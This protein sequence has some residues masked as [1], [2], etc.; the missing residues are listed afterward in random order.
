MRIYGI[1][2]IKV[3]K[4]F[5]ILRVD[6]CK[7]DSKSK[8]DLF[9]TTNFFENLSTY[10]ES[11]PKKDKIEDDLNTLIDKGIKMIPLMKGISSKFLSLID[12]G[13][14]INQRFN[15]ELE[16]AKKKAGVIAMLASAVRAEASEGTE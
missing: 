5:G 16:S 2:Y 9:L 14:S 12:L 8:T 10:Q 11:D 7:D 15:S 3:V 6:R 13:S 4:E 1:R